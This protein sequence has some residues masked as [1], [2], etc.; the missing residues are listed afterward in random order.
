MRFVL[1]VL[2]GIGMLFG[3]L[4]ALSLAVAYFQRG[5]AAGKG[6]SEA[7]AKSKERT[8]RTCVYDMDDSMALVAAHEMVGRQLRDPASAQWDGQRNWMD[9]P[10]VVVARTADNGIRA[11]CGT[12]NAK[13]GF[14]GYIGDQ[15]YVVSLENDFVK[16]GATEEEFRTACFQR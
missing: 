1:K 7:E 13:N 5:S 6:A 12:V 16:V 9:K 14:G 2:K 15:I 10:A 3:G 8:C 4:I 11:V